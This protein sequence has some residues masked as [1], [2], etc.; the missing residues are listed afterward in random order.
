VVVGVAA[1]LGA[2]GL[3]D[4]VYVAVLVGEHARLVLCFH[5]FTYAC[6]WIHVYIY[7]RCGCG[8]W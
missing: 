7:I 4:P 2:W 1:V 5:I 8:M 3:H 6:M